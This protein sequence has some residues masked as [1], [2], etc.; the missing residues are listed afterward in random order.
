MK[1]RDSGMPAEEIWS[2]FFDPVRTL[3]AFGLGRGTGTLVEF[4]SGYGTFTLPA[5]ALVSGTVHALDIEPEMI[6]IVEGKC[7]Q[8]GITNMSARVCDFVSDGTG[9][10]DNSCDAAL[11]F[12]ILHHDDHAGPDEGSPPRSQAQ[13]PVG[14]HALEPRSFHAARPL[15]GYPPPSRAVCPVGQRSRI[16]V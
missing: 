1:V 8:A 14:R 2:V 10:A 13:W 16:Q 11:L 12:N 3:A 6:R 4:G 9:L 15:A 5:A 7:R